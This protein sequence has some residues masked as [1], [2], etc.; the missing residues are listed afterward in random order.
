MR[1][2]VEKR[3]EGAEAAAIGRS[4]GG[5]TTKLHAA[6][7]AIGLPVRI[8]PTPGQHGDSPQAVGLL[9]SLR[10]S[11]MSLPM[12]PMMPVRCGPS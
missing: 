2:I 4:R 8:H 1:S 5:L 10:V 11:V 7:D 12:P 9:S 6:V 3:V